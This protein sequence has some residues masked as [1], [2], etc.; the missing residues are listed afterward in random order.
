MG[1]FDGTRQPSSGYT[2]RGPNVGEG[3]VDESSVS[4]YSG[5]IGTSLN[6]AQRAKRSSVADAI[7]ISYRRDDSEGEAGRLFDDL[8]R[9]FGNDAVFMD[10]AGIR[11]GVDFRKAIE[12]NVASCGVLL[13]IVGP[14]WASITGVDGKRRLED[15]N[16]FVALEIAS[17]LRREVP[18]IPVLVHAAKMP[19]ADLLPESLK[20]FAFRNS[21]ELSHARWN[22]DVQLLEEALKSYV[23]PPKT[24][25]PEPVH[26]TVPVQLPAPH[27][28]GAALE[29]AKGRSLPVKMGISFAT[30]LAI[31]LIVYFA[32]QS[33]TT[34]IDATYKQTPNARSATV[35]TATAP[36]SPSPVPISAAAPPNGFA[37][38]WIHPADVAGNSLNKLVISASGA[39]LTLHGYGGCQPRTCDWGSQ[40]AQLDLNQ[41]AVASFTPETVGSG[42]SRVARVTV[43]PVGN[44]LDVLVENTFTGPSGNHNTQNHLVFT[45]SN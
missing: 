11:P 28:P 34:T 2:K 18:V 9:A 27:H 19:S 29:A 14:A 45:P 44:G 20:S 26:A 35:S 32:M 36:V 21:V 37:G 31:A 42:T 1:R 3:V 33:K 39:T 41:N 8:T 43:H 5:R 24:D 7:F 40:T 15:P 23:K 12:D 17:A 30:V 38:T 16:D 13:A 10:V 22:S 4:S 25:T 6:L